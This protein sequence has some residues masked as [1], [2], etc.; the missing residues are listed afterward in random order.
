MIAMLETKILSGKAKKFK[1]TSIYYTLLSKCATQ[2]GYTMISSHHN[3]GRSLHGVILLVK[4]NIKI[5]RVVRSLDEGNDDQW[6]G[7]V[8]V[9]E[10]G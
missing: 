5:D 8:L 4:D 1:H 9:A 10:Q 7:R 6:E 3:N 2:E